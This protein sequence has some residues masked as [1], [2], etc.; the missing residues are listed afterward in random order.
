[1]TSSSSRLRPLGSGKKSQTQGKMAA[2]NTANIR[3]VRHCR[4]ANA[5]GVIMTIRKFD[6]Q[7]EQ[8]DSALAWILMRRFVIS[9]GLDLVNVG[10]ASGVGLTEVGERGVTHYNQV[11]PNH[12]M[13]KK[14]LKTKRKTV[15]VTP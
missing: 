9:A 8:V 11:M 6:S 4:L 12:P 5:G 3:Y 1:M 14:L 2:L 10:S 15:A 7:F 13:A